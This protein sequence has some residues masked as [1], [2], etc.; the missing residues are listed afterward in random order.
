MKLGAQLYSVRDFTQNA[1]DFRSTM[2]RI[3]QIGYENVQISGIGPI[4]ANLIRSISEETELP[5][6]C[7]HSPY[8]RILNDTD[9]LIAEHQVYSCPVIGLGSM[10][11]ELRKS[12]EGLERFLADLKEPVKKIR[13]AGLSFAYHNH[14]FEFEDVAD[15]EQPVYDLLLER[16]PDW[17]F[18]MDTYWVEYA[19]R[20]ATEYITKIGTE[21]LVNI[22]FK[23]MARD[24]DRSICACGRGV[25]DFAEIAKVCQ[26]TGVKNILVEQDNAV[27]MPDA[28]AEM[29]ASFRHLRPIID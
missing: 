9:A 11:K 14:A 27:K 22:H 10:P 21:R 13:A 3:K 19:G 18:I 25:L 26:S 5:V 1:E 6:V 28:F 7:T 23:D 12:A 16:C 8:D 4:D 15:L 2:K 20:S 29:E 17:H 24:A